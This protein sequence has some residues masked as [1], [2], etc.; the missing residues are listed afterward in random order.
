MRRPGSHYEVGRSYSLLKVKSFYD[1][2]AI[3]VGHQPGAGKHKGRLGAENG[4]EGGHARQQRAGADRA[5]IGNRVAALLHCVDDHGDLVV[6]DHVHDVRATFGHFIDH[7]HWNTGGLDRT[8]YRILDFDLPAQTDLPTGLSAPSSADLY[9]NWTLAA[10]PRV[11]A[12]VFN[13]VGAALIDHASQSLGLA[14]GLESSWTIPPDFNH[15]RTCLQLLRFPPF[16]GETQKMVRS[17]IR[18]NIG[19]AAGSALLLVGL[20]GA[21]LRAGRLTRQLR[22]AMKEREH[23]EHEMHASARRFEQVAKCCPDWIWQTDPLGCFTYSSPAVQTLLGIPMEDMIGRRFLDIV[24]PADHHRFAK[25]DRI[26]ELQGRESFRKRYHLVR[27]D[28]RSTL[29]ECTIAP[30]LNDWGAVTGYTGVSREVQEAT[31]T[32]HT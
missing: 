30:I 10:C 11:D 19:W 32:S 20:L 8:A 17:L 16:E 3:V 9:P 31:Q 26:W 12:E 27:A 28:G 15:A 21:N 6:L 7:R 18:E 4:R 5:R 22:T 25:G 1:A 14:A 29:H 13:L 2:E 23:A 24:D